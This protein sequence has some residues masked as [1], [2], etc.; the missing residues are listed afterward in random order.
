MYIAYCLRPLGRPDHK[1]PTIE[2]LKADRS[3]LIEERNT[4]GDEYKKIAAE[5][6]QL[7]YIRQTIQDY[8]SQTTTRSRR[9]SIE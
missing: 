7:D 1:V 2:K 4:L 9:I 3:Q 6:K 5:L 8:L